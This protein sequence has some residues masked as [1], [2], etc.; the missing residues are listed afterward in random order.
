MIGLGRLGGPIAACLAARG[1]D[2][3]GV[4]VD[5]ARVEALNCATPPSIEPGFTDM[6]RRA[7]GRFRATTDIADAVEQTEATFV[8]VPT[9]NAPGGGFSLAIVED[10]CRRIAPVLARKRGYHLIVIVSTVMPGDCRDVVVPLLEKRTG[11][12]CGVDFGLCY[13]P[14]FVA[15]GSVIANFLKPD[16]LLI[17]ASDERS[18]ALLESIYRRVCENNPTF[19]T[20]NL[21]NAELAKIAV[22]AY[23]TMKISF[24]NMLSEICDGTPGTDVDLVTSALGLDSRIGRRYLTGGVAYGGPCFPRDNIAL[25]RV[26]ERAGADSRLPSAVDNVNNHQT[27]R[28]LRLIEQTATPGDTIAVLGLAYKP[29]S[30]IFEPSQGT[31]LARALIE[32]GYQVVAC[33]PAMEHASA[34]LVSTVN[35]GRHLRDCLDRADI[36]IVTTPWPAFVDDVRPYIE[37]PKLRAVIDPWR[38][39]DGDRLNGAAQYLPGG[40]HRTTSVA[41]PPQTISAHAIVSGA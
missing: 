17:G 25:T 36:A 7:D 12:V 33:D 28:L 10:V 41:T 27:A 19:S 21:T 9:P 31:S 35:L 20:M 24:A 1:F 18:S 39:L 38:V 14:E 15:I 3:I 13:S 16:F 11:R 26:A 23:V 34:D 2:V 8:L 37:A 4:D 5:P 40:T 32:R 29:D 6:L 22:N 30:D